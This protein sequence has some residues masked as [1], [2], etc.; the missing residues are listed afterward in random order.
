MSEA[1]KQPTQ[2]KIISDMQNEL[3]RII[4]NIDMTRL[5]ELHTQIR[6]I[7][8]Y[9]NREGALW[10]LVG[11]FTEQINALP[12]ANYDNLKRMLMVFNK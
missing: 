7:E 6:S 1:T 4:Q 3:V 10:F 8:I 5:C 9:D 12:P 2:G 11:F